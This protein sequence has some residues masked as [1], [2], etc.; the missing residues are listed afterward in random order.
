[1]KEGNAEKKNV[2]TY[3]VTDTVYEKAKRKAKSQ[4]T[5]VATKVAD[6][7]YNYVSR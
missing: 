6:L 2:R 4:K 1:M 7:L 3:K 5:T